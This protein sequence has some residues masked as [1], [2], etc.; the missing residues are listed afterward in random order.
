[1][2]IIKLISLIAGLLVTQACST[3]DTLKDEMKLYVLDCGTIRVKDI[4]LFSPGV[5][6]GK[7]K[8]LANSCYLIKHTQ[9]VFL[10]DTGLNDELVKTSAGIS[11]AE[12]MFHLQVKHTL[13][14]QL[15]NIGLSPKDIDYVALSHFHFDH[16]G[17]MNLFSNAK[18][19]VQQQELDVAFSDE[20]KAMHFE[21]NHYRL[22]KK[23][24]FVG[25][26]GDFDV[27]KDGKL[28]VLSSPGHTPG[29]QSLLVNLAEKGPIL[30]SGD[31]YHFD[32]N[33]KHSRVP[34]L[35]VDKPRTLQSME[36]IESLLEDID[37]ELWIQHDPVT[38]SRLKHSPKYYK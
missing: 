24:Q 27:F 29:H 5:D 19:L 9:G 22:I 28:V 8:T 31:L 32:K 7:S 6:V 15:A 23:E 1:M 36:T 34:A 35:N 21:P 30:L 3:T 25:L 12:G 20:A 13:Q 4:S 16:T 33:R 37:G 11:V 10:W 14:S 2:K 38:F 18:F 26:S 17:N